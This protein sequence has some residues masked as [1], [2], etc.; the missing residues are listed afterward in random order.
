LENLI[1]SREQSL[2]AEYFFLSGE[3]ERA[4]ASFGKKRL[5]ALSPSDADTYGWSLLMLGD[6]LHSAARANDDK[7]KY[8]AA[9]KHFEVAAKIPSTAS[10]ALYNWGNALFDLS[11]AARNGAPEAMTTSAEQLMRR[12]AAKYREAIA[13]DSSFADA[14]NNLGNALSDLARAGYPREDNGLLRE[15]FRHYEKAIKKTGTPHVVHCNYA[16]I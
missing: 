2:S 9:I 1:R 5:K 11:M 16:K 7:A 15:A 10:D 3:Y 12:A 8:R 6:R 14:H 13:L 4:V